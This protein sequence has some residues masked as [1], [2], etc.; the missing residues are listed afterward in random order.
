[1]K[2]ITNQLE[3]VL[4]LKG[5]P[6]NINWL[7]RIIGKTEDEI[8]SA[9][10]NLSEQLK[11]RG[12]RLVKNDNEVVL[13]AA[14]ENAEILKEIVR[15]EFDSELSKA[16]VETLSVIIYKTAA[17]RAEI[18]YVRGVNSSFILRN[19]L[20]RGLIEREAKRGKDSTYIYKPT[21]KL[22]EHLGVSNLEQLPDYGPAS[23]KL[24]EFLSL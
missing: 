1:M 23:E 12:V 8:K 9:L 7:A 24:K 18:D 2:D 10:D 5:E 3:S 14:P 16:A 21:L 13:A 11:G 19:L 15:L 4:F 17:S 22:L 6:V 20:I